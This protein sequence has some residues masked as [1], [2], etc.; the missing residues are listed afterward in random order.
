MNLPKLKT[1]EEEILKQL[2]ENRAKQKKINTAAFLKKYGV[3][4]GNLVKFTAG[5][6]TTSEGVLHS[7]WYDDI[8]PVAPIIV[9]YKANGT[10]GKKPIKCPKDNIDS[11]KFVRKLPKNVQ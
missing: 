8:T 6:G 1:Q 3:E 2:E 11:F 5:N 4:I 9:Q 10:I 7:L